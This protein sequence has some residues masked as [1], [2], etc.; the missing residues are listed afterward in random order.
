MCASRARPVRSK[1]GPRPPPRLVADIDWGRFAATGATN[2][3]A[4]AAQRVEIIVD[5]R[6]PELYRIEVLV[7]EVDAGQRRFQHL[8]A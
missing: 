7:G 6:D 4:D 8:P 5:G 1:G 2:R 3:A